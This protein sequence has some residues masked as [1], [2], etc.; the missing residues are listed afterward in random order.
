MQVRFLASLSGAAR[1]HGSD[2]ALLWLWCRPAAVALIGLPSIRT[3][4]SHGCSP[5]SKI[6]HIHKYIYTHIHTYTYIHIDINT[7]IGFTGTKSNQKILDS[8]C[9][10]ISPT[11]RYLQKANLYTVILINEGSVSRICKEFPH[12]H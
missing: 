2:L 1:R 6:I 12:I 3:S 7:Y 5:K 4:I 10:F 11:K 8:I 9:R